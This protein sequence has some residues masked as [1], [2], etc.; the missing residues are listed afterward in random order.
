MKKTVNVKPLITREDHDSPQID[1]KKA[2][3]PKRV[4]PDKIFEGYKKPQK[5]KAKRRRSPPMEKKK[6]KKKY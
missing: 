2:T 3:E 1:L 6:P 4:S 5:A